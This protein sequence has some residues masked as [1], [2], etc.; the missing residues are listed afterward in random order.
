MI[1]QSFTCPTANIDAEM[2]IDSYRISGIGEAARVQRDFQCSRENQCPH[3]LNPFCRVQIL[4]R[5][6]SAPSC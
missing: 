6:F 3:S 4:N 1:H 2:A 5:R